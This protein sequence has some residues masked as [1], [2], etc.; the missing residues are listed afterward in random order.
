[1]GVFP[2]CMFYDPAKSVN[3]TSPD[4]TEVVLGTSG[5][6]NFKDTYGVGL[7]FPSSKLIS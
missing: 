5:A 4:T 7:S 3:K 2:L 1:M 6:S